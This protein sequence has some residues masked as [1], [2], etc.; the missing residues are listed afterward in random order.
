MTDKTNSISFEDSDAVKALDSYFQQKSTME[1]LGVDRDE[2]AHSRFLAWLFENEE[3][4]D[5]AIKKLISLL[6]RTPPQ[7]PR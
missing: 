7:R 5:V 3:T 1:I 4:R 2:N 6:K